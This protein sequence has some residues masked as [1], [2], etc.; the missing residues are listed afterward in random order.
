M[1]KSRRRLKSDG[2]Y[3]NSKQ[4]QTAKTFTKYATNTKR[5]KIP[6]KYQFYDFFE[7]DYEQVGLDQDDPN[8]ESSDEKLN[9]IRY[10]KKI[11]INKYEKCID[12][13]IKEYFLNGT[14]KDVL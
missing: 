11:D 3:S 5:R 1:G 14:T 9:Y 2:H 13:C 8:Y 6:Q 10:Q 4:S 12:G 7:V